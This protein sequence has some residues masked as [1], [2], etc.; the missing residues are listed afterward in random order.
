M[1]VT[2]VIVN[3]QTPDLV[4][5]AVDSFKK[6]Y[7]K[8]SLLIIDNGSK[9]ESP[10]IIRQLAESHIETKAIFLEKNIYHGPAM[11]LVMKV[12]IETEM[13]FFLD[14]DTETKKTGFLEKMVS[15]IGNDDQNYGAGEYSWVNKRGF[16]AKEGVLILQTP[17]ML[18]RKSI[19]DRLTAFEHHG[20]PTLFNFT[21][22]GSKGYKLISFPISSYID[23]KWRGTADRFGYG[24][25]WRGKLDYL[26]NKFGL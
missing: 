7:P 11:D 4:R 21:D 3:F 18:L 13:V 8:V 6:H 19:Y 12:H 16:S 20:Q 15:L 2:V 23:H 10:E 25:G 26:L 17:Y 24:L 14:S 1:D 9:D 5:I 22:A